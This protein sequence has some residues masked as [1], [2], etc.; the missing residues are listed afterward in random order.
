MAT[1]ARDQELLAR[2]A[3]LQAEATQVLAELDLG[4]LFADVGPVL[5]VG[6]YLSGLMCWRDLDVCLLAGVECSPSEVLELLKRV[7]V[8]PGFAGFTYRD[9]RGERCPTGEP[10]DERY[11]VPFD[12]DAGQERW[13]IDLSV[14]L[15]DLHGDVADWHTRLRDTITDEQRLAV[16]RIKDVW[17]RLPTYP[18]EVSGWEIYNAVLG[19]GV[20]TPEQF[21]RWLT[22]NGYPSPDAAA[23]GV[24]VDDRAG[25]YVLAAGESRRDDAIL[26]FKALAGDTG[27]LVS[28]CEFTLGAWA[29][30]PVLHRHATVDEAFSVVAG[31]LEA[32]LDDQRVQVA[33][34]GFLWVPRGTAH[35]FAN[36]GPDP[37]QV[38]A[39]ALPGG[40]EELLAEQAAYLSSVPGPPDPSVLGEIG[41]RHGAPT[42]GPPIRSK[43]A[44][45]DDPATAPGGPSEA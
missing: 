34:G 40:V 25:P 41:V 15:R 9:E 39:L 37:V 14:W 33:A 16:L 1:S 36:A 10:R 6:S 20:R 3:A 38:L 4:R 29:S 21:A 31:T 30:G 28:I 5:V 12:L 43:D 19:D 27:G 22:A 17:H 18:D 23:T 13:R 24:A 2:Q 11:H 44:P 26:P 42:L 32:Q 45:A 8:L 7:V 35:S